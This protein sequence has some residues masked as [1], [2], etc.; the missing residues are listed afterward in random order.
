MK[1]LVV[2][3][4]ESGNTKAIAEAIAGSLGPH[5]RAVKPGEA[6]D[7]EIRE[8][9]FLVVG[10]P[11]HG[12]RPTESIA[13]F[14]ERIVPLLPRDAKLATFDTRLKMKFV[15]MFGFAADRMA[16]SAADKS[17]QVAASQGFIV[18][19]RTGPLAEGEVERAKQWG[20]QIGGQ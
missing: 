12:G 13:G 16:A 17:V 11:T 2:Y 19:G 1:A 18:N 3:D 20:R 4:S 10:S 14:M 6:I 9:D 5:V 15:K 7:R 8:V